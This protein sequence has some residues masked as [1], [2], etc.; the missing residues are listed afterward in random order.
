MCFMRPWNIGF[1][2]RYLAPMLSHHRRATNGHGTLSSFKNVWSHIISA[3]ALTI[4]L[5]S[6][7]VLDLETGSCFLAHHEIR[8]EPRNTTYPP[9]DLRSSG[10]SAHSTSEKPLTTREVDRQILRPKPSVAFTYLRIRLTVVQC[11]VVGV[12]RYWQALLIAN[13]RSGLVWDKY[14]R[15]PTTLL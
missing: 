9:I 7:S 4:D 1:E 13:T 10:Q 6:A 15:A 12:L 11:T 3:V 8:L 5:Y 2:D 14:W